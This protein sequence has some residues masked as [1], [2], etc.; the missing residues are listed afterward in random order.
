MVGLSHHALTGSIFRPTTPLLAH[1]HPLGEMRHSPPSR[2]NSV[3]L[4]RRS[5]PGRRHAWGREAPRALG[6]EGDL[7]TVDHPH[8]FS[9]PLG[10]T[11]E[12][13]PAKTIF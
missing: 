7:V 5:S 3:Q 12:A 13:M 10:S 11:M 2:S 8:Q 4:A 9:D 1:L 6:D